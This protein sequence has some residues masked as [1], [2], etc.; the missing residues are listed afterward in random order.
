MPR[1]RL[2][3]RNGTRQVNQDDVRDHRDE[4]PDTIPQLTP[5]RQTECSH[6]DRHWAGYSYHPA[7]TLAE[8][9]SKTYISTRL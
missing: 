6:A 3:A 7:N 4:V 8:I 1:R 2:R 5:H 9:L